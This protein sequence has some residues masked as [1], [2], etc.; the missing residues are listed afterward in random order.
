MN[1]QERHD[2]ISGA[3][4]RVEQ[5]IDGYAASTD[6]LLHRHEEAI[7]DNRKSIGKLQEFQSRTKGVALAATIGATI[8]AAI[9]TVVARAKELF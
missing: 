5:K 2:Q 6:R 8:L 1:G 4:G 9:G 7:S 3:L